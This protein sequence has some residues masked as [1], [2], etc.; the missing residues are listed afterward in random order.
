MQAAN[1]PLIGEDAARGFNLSEIAA[2]AERFAPYC[3][4]VIRRSLI[5]VEL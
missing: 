2:M 4:A 5:K 1:S 3:L